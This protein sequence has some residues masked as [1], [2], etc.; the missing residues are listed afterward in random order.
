MTPLP[1]STILSSLAVVAL[2]ATLW[3]LHRALRRIDSALAEDRRIVA[4]L[5]QRLATIE[6]WFPRPVVVDRPKPSRS[7]DP[8]SDRSTSEPTLISVPDL[9]TRGGGQARNEANAEEP[10]S[11]LAQRFGGLW[12]LAD[13]GATPAM[14]ARATG[15]PV[16][17]VELVLGL[18][19]RASA[20]RS[21]DHEE[22]RD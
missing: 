9:A 22:P 4:T 2:V 10:E 16:G 12:E 3:G 1:L 14:I 17:T 19:R 18:R 21:W 11:S 5:G 8:S 6:A 20:S 7:V 13:A 15:M